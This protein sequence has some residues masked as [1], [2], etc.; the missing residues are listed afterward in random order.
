MNEK[1]KQFAQSKWFVPLVL[2]AFLLLA[3]P[4]FLEQDE[5]KTVSE[6]TTESR[7]EALCNEMYGVKNAKVMIS[8]ETVVSA[9]T[10]GFGSENTQK[11]C[12]IAVVC[13]GG[14]DPNVQLRIHNMLSALFQIPSTK[15]SVTGRGI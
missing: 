12:G 5:S 10:F 7:V 2:F 8:Y 13:D 6:Q 4:T 14:G 9:S 3:I 1:L 15:I 11:I